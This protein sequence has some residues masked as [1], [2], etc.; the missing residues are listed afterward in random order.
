MMI[1]PQMLLPNA[2][3]GRFTTALRN[4]SDLY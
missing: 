1:S 3:Q 4:A 2:G